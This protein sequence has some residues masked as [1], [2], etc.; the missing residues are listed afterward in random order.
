MLFLYETLILHMK[1]VNNTLKD[2]FDLDI[3]F[4]PKPV[5][6]PDNLLLLLVQHWAW[7]AHVFLMKDNWHDF[8]TLLLFQSYTGGWPAEFIH[9]LKGKTSEDPLDKAEENKNKWLLK[10][11]N[12]HD[13]NS[14]NVTDDLKYNND[15]DTDNDSGYDDNLS[16]SDNNTATINDDDLFKKGMNEG[17]NEGTNCDSGY[18]SNGIDVTMT[19]NTYDCQLINIDRAKQPVWLNCNI[20]KVDEFGEVIWKYKA[21]CYK[22]I[23][24][25]IMK[26]PKDG[27]WDVLAMKVHLQHHKG[28]NNKPKLFIAPKNDHWTPG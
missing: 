23:C 1:Y 2:K 14:C 6:E 24:L 10:R 25:W 20:D 8:A 22:D 16:N 15:S 12:K 5:T 21:L 13:N 19:E 17:M 9:S 27:E 18:N 11:Q 4:K 3:T 26:N 7:N 28:V